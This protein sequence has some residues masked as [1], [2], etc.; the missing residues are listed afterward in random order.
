MFFLDYDGTLSPLV[1]KPEDAHPS[2][3]L[4]S[5]LKQLSNDQKN[6]IYIISGRDR[7][8]LGSWLGD[9]RVGMSAEHG[10]F[11]RPFISASDN[12]LPEVGEWKDLVQ[13]KRVDVGWKDKV[14]EVFNSYAKSLKG[15]V[16]ECKEY[17]ITFHYRL[18]NKEQSKR[19]V[20]E[21]QKE[22]QDLTRQY[23][24]L[25]TLKGKK[26][27]EARLKGITKGIVIRHI[28]DVNNR[29]NLNF[30]LCV[31]DDLTDEDMY[32]ELESD[33]GLKEGIFTCTVN[34][35]GS[36]ALTFVNDQKQV[37]GILQELAEM[38]GAN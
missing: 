22:L 28:L 12:L 29:D 18:C 24:T 36:K 27:V 17:A 15:S 38:S 26:S 10:C 32:T 1:D 9:L 35:R 8:T 34:F 3:E 4:I 21:L 33:K 31:G 11:L 30:V 19:V 13:E 14:I 2:A 20:Q 23:S 16:V 6:R 37:L 25:N 7:K 5:I